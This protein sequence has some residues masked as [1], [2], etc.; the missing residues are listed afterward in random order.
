[1]GRIKD[2][3][4]SGAKWNIVSRCTMQPV[5]FLFGIILARLISPEEMGILGLTAIFF[6]IAGQLKDCGFG[7]ALIRKQDRT[8]ADCSTMF[9]F[10][11]LASLAVAAILFALAPWFASF[12]NQPDLLPLTQV[13]AVMLFLNSTSSVHWCLY[14]ARR[15]F[16][17]PAVVGIISTLFG[18]PICIFLA[19]NG[20]SYWSLVIQ[21]IASGLLSLIIVW[22]ISPWKPRFLWSWSSFRQFFGFGSKLAATGM[23]Q[24]IYDNSRTFIIGKFYT[25]AQ[26]ANF[27]KG[28]HLCHMPINVVLGTVSS[29][30]YPILATIQDDEERLNRVFLKYISITAVPVCWGMIALAFFCEDI[31]LMF[32][33]DRW[34]ASAE[35]ARIFVVGAIFG[36]VTNINISLYLVKGRTDINLRREMIIKFISTLLLILSSFYGVKAICWSAS[37]SGIFTVL[38]SMWYASRISSLS[39]RKQLS[40]FIPYAFFAVIAN[41]LGASVGF[42]LP[43]CLYLKL[44]ICILLSLALYSLFL[45]GR[46]DESFYEVF[47]TIRSCIFRFWGKVYGK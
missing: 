39:V 38:I 34:L 43:L 11:V 26:L 36:F 18:M 24:A 5:Q 37:L 19:Y 12:Y 44:T 31:V 7:A 13:S 35:Y 41:A 28:F 40:C 6:A 17:T 8:E 29:V 14:S 45:W 22:I 4:I 16:K 1:M 9:W 46:R 20:W 10:N 23:L 2:E 25:P 33:G 21:G 30:T 15:D 32:Y 27:S 3:T 47:F 42:F